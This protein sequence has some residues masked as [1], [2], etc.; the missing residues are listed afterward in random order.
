MT[1]R[2]SLGASV[3]FTCSAAHG[4]KAAPVVSP[5]VALSASAA[6]LMRSPFRPMN[7]RRSAVYPASGSLIQLNATR[8]AKLASKK[9]DA[10]MAW[11]SRSKLVTI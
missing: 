10:K 9:L 6:G 2:V 5:N 4:S 11:V 8:S 1:S 7:S 3:R